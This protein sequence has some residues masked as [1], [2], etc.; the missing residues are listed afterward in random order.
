MDIQYTEKRK[1][2][3][4]GKYLTSGVVVA[5]FVLAVVIAM[6]VIKAG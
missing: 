1:G 2:W 5:L 4:R 3:Y 6:N